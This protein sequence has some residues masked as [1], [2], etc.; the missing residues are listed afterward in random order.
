MKLMFLATTFLLSPSFCAPFVCLAD[1]HVSGYTRKDG[2]YVQPHYRTS[3]DGDFRNNWTTFGNI[4]PH[5]GELGTRIAP[6]YSSRQSDTSAPEY[7]FIAADDNEPYTG[8]DDD[9]ELDQFFP[10]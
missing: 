2:G 7:T 3:P 10:D 1:V 6:D 9:E 8:D 5:T 4:N